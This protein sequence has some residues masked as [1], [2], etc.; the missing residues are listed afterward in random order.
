M[1]NAEK[2]RIKREECKW[3]I[4]DTINEISVNHNIKTAKKN[5]EKYASVYYVRDNVKKKLINTGYRVENCSCSCFSFSWNVIV[6]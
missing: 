4:W 6:W 1:F 3:T 2:F 5:K